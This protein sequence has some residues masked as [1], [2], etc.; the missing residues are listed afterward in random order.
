MKRSEAAMPREKLVAELI[1]EETLR[2]IACSPD[3]EAALKR[4]TIPFDVPLEVPGSN[5]AYEREL[6]DLNEKHGRAYR[7]TKP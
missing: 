7:R 5:E 3:P 1:S 6:A 2:F 4:V